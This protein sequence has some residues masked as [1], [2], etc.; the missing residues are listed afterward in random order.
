MSVPFVVPHV[1][2]LDDDPSIRALLTAYLADNELRCTA[3]ATGAELDKAML[4]HQVDLVILDVRLQ[5]EDGMQIASRLRD[6]STIPIL[7]LSG[8]QDEVDRV[9]GLELGADDYLTKPFS[10]RE[11]LA[12][13]R[14]LLRRARA[15]ARVADVL[16]KARAYRFAGWELNVGLR[17]LSDPQGKMIDLTN[18]EFSLL[19]AFV[20]APQRTLTRE[21]LQDMSRLYNTEVYDRAIDVQI[22]RLR[23]KI[24]PNRAQPQFIITLRGL[25]YVFD[26]AV[27]VIH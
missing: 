14:A 22:L 6:A 8:R 16:T 23:K 5:G 19:A 12:R 25:G 1:V 20:C 13:I 7:M 4:L 3:V 15:Q 2:A 10:K 21:Q 11:L 18:G 9:M 26:A 27:E 24:E 17:R